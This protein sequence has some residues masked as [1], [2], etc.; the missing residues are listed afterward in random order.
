MSAPD[1]A[2]IRSASDSNVAPLRWWRLAALV[3][4]VGGLIVLGKTTG[5]TAYLSA[6][7]IRVFTDAAGLWGPIVFV[8]VFCVGE[9]VNVPGVIFV[10]AA[11]VAYGRLG[12]GALSFIGAV[13]AVSVSFVVVRGVG[14]KPLAAIR[15]PLAGRLLSRLDERPVLTVILLRLFLWMAPQLNYALALSNIRFRSYFVGTAVGLVAPIAG[16]VL[17]SDTLLR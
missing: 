17:L 5:L 7:R 9:L 12:G 15:W 4:L 1:H 16:I 2:G 14:G 10:G 8:V 3:A 11:V 13:A 6:E